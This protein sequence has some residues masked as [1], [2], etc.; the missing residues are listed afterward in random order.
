MEEPRKAAP[1]RNLS[2]I[3]GPMQG[4]PPFRMSSQ[5]LPTKSRQARRTKPTTLLHPL[6]TLSHLVFGNHVHFCVP[7]PR[8]PAGVFVIALSYVFC[9]F[10]GWNAGR[11]WK[12]VLWRAGSVGIISLYPADHSRDHSESTMKHMKTAARDQRMID[13]RVKGQRL[14]SRA[15]CC[16]CPTNIL[17]CPCSTKTTCQPMFLAQQALSMTET[18]VR[19]SWHESRHAYGVQCPVSPKLAKI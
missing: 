13:I 14:P 9:V 15:R 6:T 16:L 1:S 19:T 8:A 18:P 12:A 2:P 17:D 5:F 7:S 11:A 3:Q 10:L 4:Q